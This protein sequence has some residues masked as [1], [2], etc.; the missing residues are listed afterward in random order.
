MSRARQTQQARRWRVAGW[1]GSLAAASLLLAV[2]VLVRLTADGAR[3]DIMLHAQ[4][5]DTM[6]RD[7]GWIS[8]SVWYLIVH[9]ATLGNDDPGALRVASVTVLA[10]LVAGAA[11]VVFAVAHK[12]LRR[13]GLAWVIALS[14]IVV[15][16]LLN[17]ARPD[18]IYLGQLA[19]TVWHNS[20]NILAA[21]F[22]LALFFCAVAF[23]RE[24]GIRSAVALGGLSVVSVLAKP[25]FAVAFLPVLGVA[26]VV[27]LWKTRMRLGRSAVMIAAV[28]VPVT[29]L[30]AYQYLMVFAAGGV[31]ETS[32]ALRPFA[33]WS[34]H[35]DSIPLSLMLS[36]AGP[37]AALLAIG[38]ERRRSLAVVLSW[39]TV[40]V[41]VAQL[42]LLAEVESDGAISGHG[43]WFWGAHL[44]VLML[45]VVSFVELARA[46]LSWP[47][48]KARRGAIVV[49]AAL[50]ALH[51]MSGVIYAVGIIAGNQPF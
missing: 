51:V 32:P 41:A 27:V 9:L 2:P 36:L 28:F 24:P 14:S 49:A 19:P 39:S 16:P 40:V 11:A 10:V 20:T 37:L 42:A 8:Y 44:A 5:T 3:S 29:L 21:P 23:L 46:S 38:G 48:R 17:P 22:A 34:L 33:E 12:A 45:F 7:G 50:L 6:V 1:Y 18:E 30:L 15:M 13:P 35:T 25:N 43:N 4:L 47:Q 31:R 26:A